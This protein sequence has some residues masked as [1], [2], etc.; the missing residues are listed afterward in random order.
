MRTRALDTSATR[1]AAN[2][3]AFTQDGSAQHLPSWPFVAMFPL[4]PLWWTLGV[5]DVIWIV[6]GLVMALYLGLTGSVRVPRGFGLWLGF[7]LFMAMSVVQ[8]DAATDMIGF[9]Y[10]GLHYVAST[11]VFVYLYNAR[12]RLT[13]RAVAGV[14]TTFWFITVIGGY[15]GILLQDVVF[16]TPLSYISPGFLLNNELVNRM[17]IRRFAQY[18]PEG[19]VVIDPRPSAPFLYTNNWG[20]AYS[21]LL[22]FVVAYM[23]SVRSQRRFWVLLLLLPVSLIPAFA[24]L[25]RGMFLGLAL[26]AAYLAVRYLWR[27]NLRVLGGLAVAIIVVGGVAT[28]LSVGEEISDRVESTNT[29]QD[30]AEIY[31]LTLDDVAQSPLLGMGAPRPA[32]NPNIPPVGTHG[33]FW[34]VMHSHGIPAMV[35]FMGWFGFC[36]LRSRH[37]TDAGGILVSTVLIVGIME[38]FYYGFV[39]VGLYLLL[40]ACALALRPPDTGPEGP[41]TS[42]LAVPASRGDG[43]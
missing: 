30:R 34:I 8:L 16:R 10:R 2:G 4:Y 43:L 42:A 36:F 20:N 28:Q 12:A 33:Q 40:I 32:A 22:P 1:P 23:V 35:L 24:T 31:R 5:A 14:L 29:T 27:G 39:P 6:L 38:T 13:E 41:T 3:T 19:F 9:T 11:V 7:L 37:R 21:L 26:A 17:L 25:N 18:D 15:L